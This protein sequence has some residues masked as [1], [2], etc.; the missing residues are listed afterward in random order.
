[1]FTSLLGR[2]VRF[3]SETE[4]ETLENRDKIGVLAG[5]FDAVGHERLHQGAVGVDARDFALRFLVLGSEV[6][7]PIAKPG[8]ESH[9]HEQCGG[10]E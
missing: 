7:I 5:V 3:G 10:E 6:K 8:G 2:S 9:A 1:M 4:T